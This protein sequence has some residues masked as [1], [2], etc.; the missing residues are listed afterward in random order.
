[1][2][3]P[4][5]S[6]TAID[7]L[8]NLSISMLTASIESEFPF[9]MDC[10][11][12]MSGDDNK[13]ESDCGSTPYQ[14]D[15]K[16]PYSYASLITCA[17]QSTSEKKMTL[18]E[19]YQW[20]CDN[21]P[22]YCEAGSGWKNSIRHN[23][24]LNKS[25]MKI[26]RSRD[27]P[28]KGSYWCL[29][30]QG[31]D[32]ECMP[33]AP[34]RQALCSENNTRCMTQVQAMSSDINNNS[35]TDNRTE[36][37]QFTNI[38]HNLDDQ[39]NSNSNSSGLN[40][41]A[42]RNSRMRQFSPTY[43]E[44]NVENKIM[45][46]KDDVNTSTN[47]VH[48]VLHNLNNNS[49]ISGTVNPILSA[50]CNTSNASLNHDNNDNN[51]SLT[52]HNNAITRSNDH[53]ISYNPHVNTFSIGSN[54]LT[55]FTNTDLFSHRCTTTTTTTNN[56]ANNN[57][58]GGSNNDN[59]ENAENNNHI[60]YK[61]KVSIPCSAVTSHK[62]STTNRDASY[63][64]L[65]SNTCNKISFNKVNQQTTSLYY[66][67]NHQVNANMRND[68]LYTLQQ[69][70]TKQYMPGISEELVHTPFNTST[71][72]TISNAQINSTDCHVLSNNNNNQHNYT[73]NR[74]NKSGMH[75]MTNFVNEDNSSTGPL[76]SSTSSSSIVDFYMIQSDH[77]SNLQQQPDN[78][79]VLVERR[80]IVEEEGEEE[81][82]QGENQ[83]LKSSFSTGELDL[84]ASFKHLYHALFD[85]SE[86]SHPILDLQNT[87]AASENPNQSSLSS[88]KLTET[89]FK[90]VTTDSL[91]IANKENVMTS[92]LNTTASSNSGNSS[93]LNSTHH[94]WDL[95]TDQNFLS[96][97]A[98]PSTASSFRSSYSHGNNPDQLSKSSNII[99]TNQLLNINNTDANNNS[100]N[101]NY[102]L[103]KTLQA[104]TNFDW[105][106]VNL[107]EYPE[108]ISKIRSVSQN[109]NS[110]TV[111]Q[112]M[113]LNLT[114]D[115]LFSQ[116]QQNASL[117]DTSITPSTS[118]ASAFSS[119][120]S[121]PSSSSS[122]SSSSSL[123][124]INNFSTRFQTYD[125]SYRKSQQNLDITGIQTQTTECMT[126][127]SS[128]TSVSGNAP[129]ASLHYHLKQQLNDNSEY[130]NNA[131][132]HNSHSVQLSSNF[133]ELDCN[134]NVVTQTGLSSVTDSVNN[135]VTNNNNNNNS[136][137]N[138]NNDKSRINSL[139]SDLN[140][141]EHVSNDFFNSYIHCK[142]LRGNVILTNNINRDASRDNVGNVTAT[143]ATDVNNTC[144]PNTITNNMN[145]TSQSS[146]DHHNH[147]H[148]HNHHQNL[149]W[150]SVKVDNNINN[151]NDVS[152]PKTSGY[153]DNYS[154]YEES[155]IPFSTSSY[156]DNEQRHNHHSNHHH[157]Q[158]LHHD[159]H[160]HQDQHTLPQAPQQHSDE[161]TTKSTRNI[162][163][164]HDQTSDSPSINNNPV[165]FYFTPLQSDNFINSSLHGN[166][167][168]SV[169]A[170]LQSNTS[171]PITTTAATSD[172]TKAP[173]NFINLVTV[174]P[175]SSTMS[176][177][178]QNESLASSSPLLSNRFFHAHDQFTQHNP[179]YHMLLS[180][181][182][183]NDHSKSFKMHINGADD[184]N[185]SP[186]NNHSHLQQNENFEHNNCNSNNNGN[187]VTSTSFDQFQICSN[188]SF[189]YHS[190][191]NNLLNIGQK[192]TSNEEIHHFMPNA[193]Q[194]CTTDYRFPFI[195]N[196]M[197]TSGNLS[198]C[199]ITN[200][201]TM[202][203][204]HTMATS[205]NSTEITHLSSSSNSPPQLST[206]YPGS[207]SSSS[208]STS[209]LIHNRNRLFSDMRYSGL[210]QQSSIMPVSQQVE[211]C[212]PV[213]MINSFSI[214]N[215]TTGNNS[216][217]G[218][219]DFNWDTIV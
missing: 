109:P 188:D 131:S 75:E 66:P 97:Y 91:G 219:E 12:S 172:N 120:V 170:E 110:L 25:F 207:S 152:V 84:S 119:A 168:D 182:N 69:L 162:T 141:Y 106:S 45:H 62:S 85:N 117:G 173:Q 177:E 43:S 206:E 57:I 116:I 105:T 16:P 78:E 63:I 11:D 22:Y 108:L 199:L 53:L 196:F 160:H 61:G 33:S 103:Q 37:L 14:P 186:L 2:T 48:N 111:E 47:T 204:N 6:L 23:L 215:T 195:Q 87:T 90:D 146:L 142:D 201:T 89:S 40:H 46:E 123:P 118:S 3:D 26:P 144:N 88:N 77:S 147:H 143:S 114:L 9:E 128:D 214:Q 180:A 24:S 187:N 153:N 38:S 71:A 198:T 158:H 113:E 49:T 68:K 52:N 101:L 100:V 32:P 148:H 54:S 218:P 126:A 124:V 193:T 202:N 81:E 122:S 95:S 197:T 67:S 200:T 165:S 174:L 28:G 51:L 44:Y 181:R 210:C 161:F 17:I 169:Y 211:Q 183:H 132:L 159:P 21:F 98:S 175:Q 178:V 7:W 1:M 138:N 73:R 212:N 64:T 139:L 216:S 213:N 35:I 164:L 217:S 13:T 154:T 137:N 145:I 107:E 42:R 19:I 150:T 185:H 50:S 127:V 155:N 41:K 10:W 86:L 171:T 189:L 102:V 194:H 76:L 80:K 60:M 115:Q 163:F 191:K 92:S 18:S 184:V 94:M 65:S 190:N 96:P 31:D 83:S 156:H 34:K 157:L 36:F 192:T 15:S 179:R 134:N 104:A 20:I 58:S 56:N 151:N 39:I 129:N 136:S 70:D 125:G 112:L 203:T 121:L 140:T 82:E 79:I 93:V 209:L 74:S 149:V 208:S 5:N 167:N 135:N 55:P 99:K 27:E 29:S 133:H 166:T 72:S 4:D 59:D 8:P 205:T 130:A 176:S 30:N